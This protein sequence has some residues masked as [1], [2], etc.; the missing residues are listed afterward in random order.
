L[1]EV[2]LAAWIGLSV[3]SLVGLA[4]GLMERI[5]ATTYVTWFAVLTCTLI[6]HARRARSLQ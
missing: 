3:S 5:L 4:Q 1:T 2:G 6:V